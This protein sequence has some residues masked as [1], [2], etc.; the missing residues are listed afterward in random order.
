MTF[1]IDTNVI[2]ELMK[3]QPDAKVLKWFKKAGSDISISAVSLEEIYFG[4]NWQPNSAKLS[5]FEAIA[6]GFKHRYGITPAIAQRAGRLRGHLQAE[7]ITRT[8]PDMLIA[9]TAIEHQLSVVTRN[10]K[11]FADCGV[12]VINPFA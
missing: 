5:L 2:S 3:K 4:L 1:L 12:V 8:A 6:Q 10:V 9:A 11:D 7:G